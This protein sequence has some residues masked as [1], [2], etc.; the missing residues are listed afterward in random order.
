MRA[1]YSNVTC[2]P[3]FI[4][5]LIRVFTDAIPYGEVSDGIWL[6]GDD[7]ITAIVEVGIDDPS[8]VRLGSE[9]ARTNIDWAGLG[10]KARNETPIVNCAASAWSGDTEAKGPRDQAFALVRACQKALTDDPSVGGIVQYC[11][12]SDLTTR[13]GQNKTGAVCV[14]LFSVSA[15]ART[16]VDGYSPPI[17]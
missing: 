4:D 2:L 3:E 16:V 8:S 10:N 17:P 12:V 6:G 5:G 1:M 11:L 9:S 14:V 13:Q 15:H 7:D